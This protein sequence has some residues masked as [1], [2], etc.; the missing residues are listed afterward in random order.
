MCDEESAGL[1]WTGDQLYFVDIATIIGGRTFELPLCP[2]LKNNLEYFQQA[3]DGQIASFSQQYESS[4]C[5]YSRGIKTFTFDKVT[6]TS[7]EGETFTWKE[8]TDDVVTYSQA[9]QYG[10]SFE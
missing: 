4:A 5:D 9:G 2:N 10:F 1:E 7:M 8:G 3:T 6:F